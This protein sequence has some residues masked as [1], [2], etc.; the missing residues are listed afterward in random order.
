MSAKP[1]VKLTLFMVGGM[2]FGALCIVLGVRGENYPLL[3]AG[4]LAVGGGIALT[5]MMI[6][7]LT[8]RR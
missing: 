3:G 8:S 5:V 2:I 1:E 4:I 7:R 6:Q